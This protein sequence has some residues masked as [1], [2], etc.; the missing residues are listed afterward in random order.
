M[1]QQPCEGNLAG[2]R[3]VF[4]A[5]LLQ[6]ICELEDVGEVL[7]RVPRDGFAEVVVLKVVGGFLWMIQWVKLPSA[8][9]INLRSD[10]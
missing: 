6:A 2:S 8:S 9:V 3:V 4:L 1:S 10:R 7:L 5:D